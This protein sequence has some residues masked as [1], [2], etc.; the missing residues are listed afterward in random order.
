[1]L[2]YKRISVEIHIKTQKGIYLVIEEFVTIMLL[3][4]ECKLLNIIVMSLKRS[5]N[6][7]FSY[8][9]LAHSCSFVA[10]L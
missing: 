6:H 2:Y 1:M 4:E 5:E 7:P 9:S 10:I 3:Q 8:F